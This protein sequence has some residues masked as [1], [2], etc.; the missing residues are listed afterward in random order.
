MGRAVHGDADTRV[1]TH[2]Y[3][4]WMGRGGVVWCA[5]DFGVT[6]IDGHV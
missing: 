5:M 1:E 6:Q 2:N 4:L 3:G